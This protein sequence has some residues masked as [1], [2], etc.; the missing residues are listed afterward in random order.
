MAEY[1]LC[2]EI[3]NQCSNNQMRDVDFQEVEV[4]DTDAYIRSLEPRADIEK[5]TFSDGTEEI[6]EMDKSD[7]PHSFAI[8]RKGIS[9]MRLSHLIKADDPSPFPA[10]TQIEAW[11]HECI[12]DGEAQG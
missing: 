3:F 1:E 2:C 10:L 9:W 12:E 11:G 5:E 8:S 7:K 4:A 6:L